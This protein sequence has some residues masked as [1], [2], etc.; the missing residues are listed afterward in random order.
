M[1]DPHAPVVIVRRVMRVEDVV[2]NR[3]RDDDVGAGVGGGPDVDCGCEE[4]ADVG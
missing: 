2:V 3:D 4:W 1:S